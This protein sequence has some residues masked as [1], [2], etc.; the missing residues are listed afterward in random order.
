MIRRRFIQE[1]GGGQGMKQNLF[2]RSIPAH[3]NRD[4]NG[5]N[6]GSAQGETAGKK[7]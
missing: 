4:G 2:K 6:D 7:A 1:N 5:I 3:K